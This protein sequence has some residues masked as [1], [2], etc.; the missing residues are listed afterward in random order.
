MTAEKRKYGP[1][2]LPIF[3]FIIHVLYFFVFSFFLSGQ[4]TKKIRFI[5]T[6]KIDK[7]RNDNGIIIS[8][9]IITLTFIIMCPQERGVHLR[10]KDGRQ[11]PYEPP[12]WKKDS[13]T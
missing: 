2:S 11:N 3:S 10:D 4:Q 12:T 1:S 13:Q 6:I 7:N 8:I 9:T 5:T